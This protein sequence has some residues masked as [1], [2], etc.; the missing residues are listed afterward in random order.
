MGRILRNPVLI[1][2]CELGPSLC[3]SKLGMLACVPIAGLELPGSEFSLT[4]VG[5]TEA[6]EDVEEFCQEV[7]GGTD[8]AAK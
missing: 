4:R 6:R 5:L 2:S 8:S 7:M 3:G 1:G